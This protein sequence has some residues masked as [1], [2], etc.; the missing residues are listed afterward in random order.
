MKK[1]LRI[2]ALL[3]A[4]LLLLCACNEQPTTPPEQTP[5]A[6]NPPAQEPQEENPTPQEPS[7]EKTFEQLSQKEQALYLIQYEPLNDASLLSYSMQMDMTISGSVYGY[8][9]TANA[10][11]VL[12]VCFPTETNGFSHVQETGT[13]ITATQ[14]G[15]TQTLTQSY[16]TGYANGK[17]FSFHENSQNDGNY[18]VY[19]ELDVTD[20][21]AHRQKIE[22]GYSYKDLN[23]SDCAQISCNKAAAGYEVSF[24]GFSPAGLDKLSTLWK[25]LTDLLGVEVTDVTLTLSVDEKLMPKSMQFD[26]V[27]GLADAPTQMQIR[28][29]YSNYNQTQPDTVDFTSYRKLNDLRAVEIVQRAMQRAKDAP[30]LSFDYTGAFESQNATPT[31]TQSSSISISSPNGAYRFTV[32][33]TIN[34]STRLTQYANGVI[35]QTTNGNTAQQQMTTAQAR[36]WVL[37]FVTPFEL[38]LALL[39]YAEQRFQSN[40]YA[41]TF[42]P[43][44]D[45]FLQFLSAYGV[46]EEDIH[47]SHCTLVVTLNEDGTLASIQYDPYGFILIGSQDYDVDF[48]VTCNNYRY[49]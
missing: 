48:S 32:S 19:S 10:Q 34:E 45:V 20:F 30:T 12:K 15:E 21:L 26:L 31:I 22:E 11:S 40:T 25:G 38:D 8:S 1:P 29:T 14:G 46:D 18:A 2:V 17:M 37:P 39:D 49:S 41:F 4:F 9:L 43:G 35:T 16:K 24:S 23:A 7:T 36:Q 5:S 42:D 33:E 47:A 13:V 6:Q 27:F 3:L 28:A 44:P